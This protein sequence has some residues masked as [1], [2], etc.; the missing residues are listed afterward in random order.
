MAGERHNVAFMVG[1]ICGAAGAAVAALFRTPLSG[2][3]TREQLAAR[4]AEFRARAGDKM[5]AALQ[6]GDGSTTADTLTVGGESVL[7]TG[8]T[9]HVLT[10]DPSDVE[11]VNT[12]PGSADAPTSMRPGGA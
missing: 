2:R 7:P 5:P 9:I 4:I 1:V 10:P 3:E 6:G 12:R 8:P 11:V